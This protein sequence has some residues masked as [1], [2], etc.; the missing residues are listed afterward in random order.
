[1]RR[2]VEMDACVGPCKSVSGVGWSIY[3]VSG[4]LANGSQLS[5][6]ARVCSTVRDKKAIRTSVC[7]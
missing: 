3:M 4:K 2:C 1:M 5:T 6:G 7:D